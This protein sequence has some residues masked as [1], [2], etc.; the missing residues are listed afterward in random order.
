MIRVWQGQEHRITPLAE[1]TK[2]LN[3][4]IEPKK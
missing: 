1:A 3:E 2:W 4:K